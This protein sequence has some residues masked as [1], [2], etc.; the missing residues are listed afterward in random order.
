MANVLEGFLVRL[1]F[2]IDEDGM[3]RFQNK[4]G[5]VVSTISTIGKTATAVAAAASA[6]FI[7]TTRDVNEIYKT[8]NSTGASIQGVKAVGKDVEGV[9]GNSAAV[10]AS[11][12]NLASNI[13][14]YGKNF[15]AFIESSGVQLYDQNGQLRDMSAVFIDL[16]NFLA[17]IAKVDP[18]MAR[19][20]AET[21]GLGEAF[22]D[23][24]RK[25]FHAEFERAMKANNAFGDSL[26]RN[27]KRAHD[28]TNN[29]GRLWDSLATG[30]QTVAMDFMENTGIDK[31]LSDLVDSAEK[32]IPAAV[33]TLD[34]VTEQYVNGDRS[35]TK[36]VE[37]FQTRRVLETVEVDAEE[38]PEL[39]ALLGSYQ[40]KHKGDRSFAENVSDKGGE[41]KRDVDALMQAESPTAEAPSSYQK[42]AILEKFEDVRGFRN[43]NPGNLRSGAGQAGTDS[44]GYAQFASMLD[45][46]KAMVR[47]ISMYRNAGLENVASIISKWAP[48]NENDTRAYIQSVVASIQKD[49]GQ[50]VSATSRLNLNDPKVMNSLI[51]AMIDHENGRGASDYF[52][53][54]AFSQALQEA[55]QTKQVS[56]VV[57]ERDKIPS[58][59]TVNQS[60]TV[61]GAGDPM[62]T[63]RTIQ[64]QTSE[65]VNRNAGSNIM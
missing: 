32:A 2:D 31:W 47:Q 21:L 23:L 49:L 59:V 53:G 29:L 15:E 10:T 35:V 42:S 58:T 60:I 7:K 46:Y 24:M 13:K 34:A 44:G 40:E 50:G 4:L 33:N 41:S 3:L 26:D 62:Q 25:D 9:G 52:G 19:M 5:G 14:T 11:F 45:G 16:R 12:A 22:D 36:D 30:A 17:E 55:M 1:G 57:S 38:N 43:N 54:T 65:T 37:T 18:G 56:S 28:F 61:N 8:S 6:A 20:K 48:S 51:D 63:A 39:A 64:R 27:S